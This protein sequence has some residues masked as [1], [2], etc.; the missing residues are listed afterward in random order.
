MRDVF[1]DEPRPEWI[2]I[3]NGDEPEIQ[4]Q[5]T[6]LATY[7]QELQNRDLVVLAIRSDHVSVEHGDCHCHAK[8]SDLAVRY[9]LSL[10][11]FWCALID[12]DDCMKWAAPE[13]IRFENIISVIDEMPLR[14]AENSARQPAQVA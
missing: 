2:L 5:T 13:P 9:G 3:V 10:D 8:A 6:A 11:Q 14:D 1:E 7:A 4:Q 12:K